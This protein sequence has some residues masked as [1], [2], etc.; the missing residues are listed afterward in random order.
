MTTLKAVSQYHRP[1]TI[2]ISEHNWNE[3]SQTYNHGNQLEQTWF[4]DSTQEPWQQ[5]LMH[6][7]V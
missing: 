1:V 4:D 2:K 3:T 7:K 5:S 6:T